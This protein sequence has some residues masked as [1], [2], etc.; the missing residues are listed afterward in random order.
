M[1]KYQSASC[2]RR[3]RKRSDPNDDVRSAHMP[4]HS[5]SGNP[6]ARKC[7][8]RSLL[9]VQKTKKVARFGATFLFLSMIAQCF[10][11]DKTESG[12]FGGFDA[13]FNIA[14]LYRSVSSL[15]PFVRSEFGW[16]R[17]ARPGA[18][19]EWA[20]CAYTRSSPGQ[21]HNSLSTEKISKGRRCS[22]SVL[23]GFSGKFPAGFSIGRSNLTKAAPRRVLA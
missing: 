9:R 16:A 6:D 5:G 13:A 19:P 1:S 17:C 23:F 21:L 18:S 20:S 3:S 22:I 14:Y 11:D 10:G 4:A 15:Y 2:L 8:Y 7:P 12:L